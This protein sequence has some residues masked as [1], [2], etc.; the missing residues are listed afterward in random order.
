MNNIAMDNIEMNKIEMD[1]I[2]MD[3]I[4]ID[5]LWIKFDECIIHLYRPL[6]LKGETDWNIG[7]RWL[8]RDLR[9]LVGYRLLEI[10]ALLCHKVYF[11]KYK[12]IYG[13]AGVY[14]RMVVT[15]IEAAHIGS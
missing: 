6:S 1:S 5:Y 4:D 12:H 7:V 2:D 10:K 15:V 9:C 8:A 11:I 13:S 14:C 3:N